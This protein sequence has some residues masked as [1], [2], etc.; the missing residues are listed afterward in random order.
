MNTGTLIVAGC[1][2]RHRFDA[3]CTLGHVA[4]EDRVA[5]AIAYWRI[6]MMMAFTGTPEEGARK[7]AQIEKEAPHLRDQIVYDTESANTGQHGVN[8]R[9]HIHK[10][11]EPLIAVTHGLHGR[12]VALSL[13]NGFGDDAQVMIVPAQPRTEAGHLVAR[14]IAEAE[15]AAVDK[16]IAAGTFTAED[17]ALTA[18]MQP[19]MVYQLSGL[20]RA[21]G[22]IVGEPT[23]P[24]AARHTQPARLG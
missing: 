2:Y 15:P 1:T 6:G 19:G 16:N 21:N 13:W 22:L 5:T 11:D 12:R 18:Q 20:R 9:A 17:Y 3:N 10:I 7:A 14:Y 24:P 8:L 4:Q 23:S